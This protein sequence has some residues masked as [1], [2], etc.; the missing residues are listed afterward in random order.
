MY[1]ARESSISTS[2]WCFEG[3]FIFAKTEIENKMT[4][5]KRYMHIEVNL[6]LVI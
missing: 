5:K 3:C 1:K 6:F 4:Q 2:S